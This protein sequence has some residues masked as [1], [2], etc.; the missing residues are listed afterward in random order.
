M[1][2]EEDYQTK[3]QD[4]D[5]DSPESVIGHSLMWQANYNNSLLFAAEYDAY[6]HKTPY[7]ES[8]YTGI[9]QDVFYLL[10]ATNM[11]SALLEIGFISNPDDYAVLS[12]A[13]GQEKIAQSLFNAFSNYKQKYDASVGAGITA[14]KETA[15]ISQDIYYGVQI[16]GLARL[17]S[18]SYPA[19]KGQKPHAVKAADSN[20]YKYIVGRY[21]SQADASL[22]LQSVRKAFPE[23][24]LVKVD[25]NSVTRVK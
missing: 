24:F 22:K 14:S 12:S 5:P 21:G 19:F 17:L 16:M 9:H 7:R 18:E 20:I 8:N 6:I 13:Q 3:Y 11:P 25:G 10:W 4:F 1:L 15:A 23:A 2:L